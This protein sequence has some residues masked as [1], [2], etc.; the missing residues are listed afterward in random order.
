MS[1]QTSHI[2]QPKP[3]RRKFVRLDLTV[4][5]RQKQMLQ[6]VA[7]FRGV[8]VSEVV[9]GVLVGLFRNLRRQTRREL[10]SLDRE[11]GGEEK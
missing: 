6:A 8:G 9:R 2:V 5:A 4:T 1:T 7:K 11:L 3:S 10:E